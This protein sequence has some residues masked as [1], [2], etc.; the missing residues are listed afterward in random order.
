MDTL[1]RESERGLR[2]P[3]SVL[4]ELARRPSIHSG[5][6][7]EGL[8]DIA[9]AAAETL[10]VERVGI[11][12][13]T[14]DR[15]AIRCIEL[16]E[17]TPRLHTAGTELRAAQ[18]PVYFRA[19]E[20]ERVITAHDARLDPRTSAFNETYLTPLGVSSMLDAPV[21][22]MGQI[23]GVV[24]VEHVGPART[25]TVE[26]ET[27][28]SSVADLVA[29]ALD[30]T[31]RRQTQEALR[32]RVEFERLISGISSRFVNLSDEE[33]DP[34]IEEVLGEI[35]RFVGAEAC[36][37]VLLSPDRLSIQVTHAWEAPG[38]P[39]RKEEYATPLPA[40]S[41]P[42][43]FDRIERGLE[44]VNLSTLDDLPPEA[45]NERRLF[46]RHGVRS[47][48]FV[49][50]M[51]K[52]TMLGTVGASL[53][54]REVRWSDETIALLRIAGEIIG[55]AIERNRA[56]G[57]LRASEQRHRLL[58]ERNLAGVYHNTLDGR[59][60]DCNDALPRMLGYD[61]K[62]EFLGHNARDHYFDPAE[63]EPL[64][65]TILE[66]GG[67]RGIELCLRRKDGQPVWLLESVHLV[68]GPGDTHILEGTVIDITDRKL[69]E[70]ALRESEARYRLM[71]ENS[72]DLIA[73]TNM[74]GEIVYASDA[75]RTLLGYEPWEMTG[76]SMFDF[77]HPD[78]H[79]ILTRFSSEVRRT[80]GATATYSYRAR[81]KDGEMVWFESTSRVIFD[82]E[83]HRMREIVSVSRDV[84]ERRRAE[85]QIEY[86][87]YH[88]ALT[89]LPNRL[90]FRDRLTIA[91][92]HSKRQQTP[93]T[94]MFLDLD[95]FKY[96]NDTLGHSLGDELLRAV[97]AR[98]RSVLREGDTIA[99]MGGD[100]FTVLLADNDSA[101][102]A[103]K[104]AQKLLDVVARPLRLE[105][106]ELYITTS[107][108]IALY[109]DDGDT[110][111]SLLKNADGAMYRA[112]ES[113]RSSYQLCTRAMNS[114]TAE[115]LSVENALRRVL[116]RDELVIHYQPQVRLD[117]RKVVGMEAL[118]RWNRPGHGLVQPATFIGIAEET[119]MIVPI[120]EWVLR[121]ACRQ[122][123]E[124]QKEIYPG[125]RIAVNLSPR[126]FQQTDLREVV[127]A[128]L[129]ESGL[130]PEL[131]ELE[132]TE[133]TAMLNT[134]RTIATLAELREL[135][136]RIAVDDFGTGHSSLNYLRRFPIDR[137]KIDR[138][139]VQE[140]ESS[141]SNRAIVSAIVAMA[142]GLSLAVTAEGVETDA[143]VQFLGEQGCEEV[144]GYLFGRPAGV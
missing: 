31:E 54:T 2:K 144:Q 91:L 98:L 46:A 30:A 133:S 73:R 132:I 48:L 74:D 44:N 142:H 118:L 103:A 110:A 17:R 101:E 134:E 104:T 69:A 68:D 83:T 121:Q 97:A 24:C 90:L 1:L 116:E 108:G 5:N 129:A 50:M 26:D 11:W 109:P 82:P 57:A 64:L 113:G 16:F 86:Q 128:A 76:R 95:R 12:F 8:S 56:Y 143:Q 114:R 15:Q 105:G 6:L 52:K 107:I 47:V 88:D 41:F 78:D 20:T 38:I 4:V 136:V 10:E 49:P 18:F 111:E 66:N 123:K 65:K 138:E 119:R 28:A 39:S 79:H 55:S 32:H 42:W 102:D 126:Q 14:P 23:T 140:I 137:V 85:E 75:V 127:A 106:H 21:R 51:V 122:A 61:S 53:L 34:S 36:H 9:E 35:A 40:A 3:N 72:T 89:G 19:L 22:R 25:W 37:V 45:V 120:G 112:K 135:G 81:R 99:R 93:L 77:V 71:A 117:T 63:R 33:L 70:T 125:L 141:R 100:E 84:S 60:L 13:F 29:M 124:W 58:F 62:E 92:A 131:L 87:A 27:F 94:V 130:A 67:M 96:V 59:M 115:R 43:W 139:F 80:H 7:A